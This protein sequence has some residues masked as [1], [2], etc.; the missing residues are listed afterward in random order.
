MREN[1]KV[2]F[3]NTL[4]GFAALSV[5]VSHYY[6]LFWQNRAA[7]SGFTTAPTLA[8]D[9]YATP[10]WIS[11]LNAIP[12]FNWG[13]YGVALFFIISGFVIPFSLQKT[14]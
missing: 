11:W 2:D 10:H 9:M 13:S 1:T 4:R 12:I 6:G 7:V 8:V 3:A 14:S 5:L